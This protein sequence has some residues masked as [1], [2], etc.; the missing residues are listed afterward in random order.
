MRIS[1]FFV[2]GLVSAVVAVALS[3]CSSVPPLTVYGQLTDRCFETRTTDD[4]FFAVI[5]ITVAN[6]SARSVIL[7]EARI[8][9]VENATVREVSVSPSPTRFSGFGA[10]P[11]GELSPAQRPLYNDRGPVNGAVIE[12]GGTV[13]LLVELHADDYTKYAGMSGLRLKYDDGWFSAS[14]V[15]DSAVGFVPP[16][17]NCGTQS[18]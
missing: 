11:G 6:D 18:R 1:R 4:G 13:E 10:A 3:G 14:S 2:G 5:G 7:R 12:A 9:E 15:A 16:W 17:A 8:L